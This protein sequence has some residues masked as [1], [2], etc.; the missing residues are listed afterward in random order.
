MEVVSAESVCRDTNILSI[1]AI[2]APK[3]DPEAL[4]CSARTLA[5][6]NFWN[7]RLLGYGFLISGYSRDF[8]GF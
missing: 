5:I 3:S 4:I 2:D 7:F 1:L 8:D 6:L